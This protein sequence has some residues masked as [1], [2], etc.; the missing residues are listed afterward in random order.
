M[1]AQD[2]TEMFEIIVK[3]HELLRKSGLKAQ[4]EKTKFF[5][6]KVQ[7]LGHVVG[8]DGIQPVKKRVADLKALKSP[9]KIRDVMRVLGCLGFYSMY[10]KNLYVDCKPFYDLT[11]TETKFVWTTEQE[12]LFNDIKERISEDTILAIPDTKHPFHVHVDASSIVVGSILVQEFPEG[13]RIV[14]FNSR[15]YAKEEQEMSTTARE[16]CG[17]ISA[18]QTYEHYLIGSP[19]PVYV[20]TDH[21]PL[22][23]LWGRRG[24]LSHRFFRY[25]LVISQYQNLKIIWTEGKNLAFPDILSRNVKI[26]D[27]DKYRLKQKQIAKDISFYD[28]HGNK[29]K[30]FN[31]RDIEK[32]PADDFFPI[33]K[34]SVTGIDKFIFKNDEMVKQKYDNHQNRPCSINN[35]SE[36]FSYGSSINHYRRHREQ[37]ITP[38][39]EHQEDEMSD[40]YTEIPSYQEEETSEQYF[41]PIS[42]FELFNENQPSD[43][44]FDE[45]YIDQNNTTD[46]EYRFPLEYDKVFLVKV[47]TCIDKTELATKF[48][49]NPK[50]KDARELIDKLTAF[51]KEVDLNTSVI[52]QEQLKDPVL[53]QIRQLRANN[54]KDE[55]I[56]ELRQSKAKMSYI[57]NFEKLSFVGNILCS[58][59]QTDEPDIEYLKVFVP[60]S[61]FFKAFQLAHSE[62]S[63][64]VG[65]DETLA[66]V[67]IFFYW[68][69]LYKWIENLIADCLDCQKNKQKR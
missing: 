44:N 31:L 27:L 33:P 1:Q 37:E 19:H 68:P 36:D 41:D 47:S 10:I 9:E 51:S 55:K 46:S 65:L 48:P 61:L 13:K 64:H 20:Y 66:N 6:R 26:K 21:K 3:Y 59:Q 56:I 62:L 25:Q 30:Y 12:T 11:R 49:E 7:F 50:I 22:M 17:V 58:Q 24:K 16:L 52:C 57:N 63:G 38:V 8:K 35:I 18:L 23:Y 5:L 53:Q 15:I 43:L 45:L 60:L 34:Q 32:G 4:T 14:S 67:K 28:E 39:S 54:T 2:E 69:G 29:E 42:E 40:H